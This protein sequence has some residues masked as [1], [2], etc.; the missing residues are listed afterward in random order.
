MGSVLGYG[1]DTWTLFVGLS[2]MH[3]YEPQINCGGSE[4]VM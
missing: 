4:V 1:C 3:V 2:C